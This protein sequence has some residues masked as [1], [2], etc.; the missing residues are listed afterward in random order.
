MRSRAVARVE[1]PTLALLGLTYGLWLLGIGVASQ[2]WLPLGMLL[3]TLAGVQHS[4][5]CHEALHGH[6]TRM[7]WLNEALVFPQ[8][9]L[10]I[11]YGRFRDLHLEHHR[12]EQLTDPYDDP[13]SNYRDPKAWARFGLLTRLLL[14]AN[15]TLL[16]RMLIGP[17]VGQVCFMRSDFAAIRAGE[18]AVLRAWVAHIVSVFVVIWVFAVVGQMPVWAFLLASYGGHSV[19]K[20]RTFLEHR[21]DERTSGRTVIVED[22][23]LLALLF[24][25]NNY[26]VV[27]HE[28]PGVPWYQLPSAFRAEREGVMQ[29]NGGYYYR[30]YREVFARHFLRRKDPVAHPLWPK[31]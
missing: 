4:S 25:N 17:I 10:C 14:E 24:L 8:L 11:P 22:R 27:H 7:R 30:S 15:N 28:R 9:T 29:R 26:H 31:E 16:G 6:P 3:V 21:A 1:W 19:L 5:L 18:R 20:I 12:D 13:E 2:L 23:G